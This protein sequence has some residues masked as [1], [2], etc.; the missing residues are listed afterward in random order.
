MSSAQVSTDRAEEHGHCQHQHASSVGA[1]SELERG[2]LCL[3]VGDID[4]AIMHLE[5][6]LHSEEGAGSALIELHLL[7]ADCVW[8]QA[9]PQGTEAA[10]PHYEAA[11]KLA[12]AAGDNSQC[13]M[14]AIGH[15][16]AL[17]SL[18]RPAEAR[19]RLRYAKELAESS[20]HLQCAAFAQRMLEQASGGESAQ[21]TEEELMRE[22]WGQFAESAS[23]GKSVVLFL[24]GTTSAPGDIPSRRGVEKLLSVG[25]PTVEYVDATSSSEALPEGLSGNFF[26]AHLQLPHL[27]LRGTNLDGWLDMGVGEL[28]GHL[29]ASG[30]DLRDPPEHEEPCHGSAAFSEG[31]EPWEVALVELVS[32]EGTGDWTGKAQSLA[33]LR[34]SGDDSELGPPKVVD[35]PAIEA[36]WRRLAPIVRKK[37][38]SQPE[39]PCGHSCSTCP[40]RHDCQLHEAVA[41]DIEDLA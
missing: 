41:G 25:C 28:R 3:S 29:A 31:L 34:V 16:C 18:G 32:K 6:A 2:K 30:V 20:G 33:G 9:G 8:R 12:E 22:T 19:E 37:L 23:A 36:A 39:M 26:A 13:G 7:L 27:Y 10:L 17:N 40:T 5:A 11:M 4:A 15:G 1:T 35:A 24:C 38:E 21:K 14:I